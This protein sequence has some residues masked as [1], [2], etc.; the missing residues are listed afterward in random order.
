MGPWQRKFLFSFFLFLFL[1]FGPTLIFYSLGYRFDF[2]KKK[3]TKTG[4]IFI[5]ALPKEVEVLIEGKTKKKTDP[6]FGSLLIENLLP[7][8]YK[9]RVEKEGYFPWEKELEVEEEKVTEVKNLIL[10]P[11]D[12]NFYQILNGVDQ[13]W[14][15]PNQKELVLKEREGEKWVL[16]SYSLEKKLKSY[17]ASQDDF[18]RESEFL[19]L[20]F[21][22]PDQ[23]EIA[24]K[25]KG[26][27]K[28]FVLD[29]KKS[30][31]QIKEKK[32]GKIP[33]NAICFKKFGGNF[34]FFDKSGYLFKREERLNEEPL[35]SI[36]NCKL[37][38]FDGLIFL[39]SAGNLYFLREEK[40]EKIFEN[41]KGIGAFPDSKKVAIFSDYEIW[42]FENGKIEFLNR[43]SEKIEKL[44]WFNEN[45]LILLSGGKI[46][47]SELD[48]RDKINVYELAEIS[49]EGFYFNQQNKRI[50]FKRNGAIFESDPLLR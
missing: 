34:Y 35:N 16:K 1:V 42:I 25:I 48:K 24:V 31:P 8:K 18:G 37:E 12:L 28:N 47:I 49:G 15:L 9:V 41:L 46:K 38:I 43:F 50:Y 29:L 5:K 11:K 26:E 2:E 20:N 45:Y 21:G 19:E 36:E 27:I 6:F 3:I 7:K 4:G 14:I 23:I 32:E 17:L 13:F 22:E 10:F 33:E 30:P 44:Y 40:F 39:E